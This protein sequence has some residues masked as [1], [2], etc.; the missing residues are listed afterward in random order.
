MLEAIAVGRNALL[1]LGVE[2]PT[3]PDEALIGKALQTLASQLQGRKIEELVD[4]PV[5]T[6][7]QTQAAMQLLGMLFAPIF[8]GMPGL[9]PLLSSTMVS[10]S[11]SFG[12]APA[13]TV[14]YA[15]HGMVL[16]AFLGEVETGYGFGQLAL[17]CSIRFN[18]REF[19]SIILLLFGGF[20][21]HRQECSEGNDTNAERWLYGW[22]GNWRFSKRWLQHNCLLLYQLF[23]W[24]RTGHLGTEIASYSAALAQV[25]QYSAQT[26]LDMMQ[27]T[28]QNLREIV[29]QPDCLIGTAYDETVMI[30]KHHQDNELQ[31][32][33]HCLHLQTV[34]CL[35][36][37]Q[38]HWLP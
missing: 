8:Q 22:H 2:L 21:Q 24:G 23:Q 33:R 35:L 30:P 29:N 4:L 5:M 32:D 14:G 18:A 28:V 26:F 25:K 7:P 9:L 13:S 19:K 36:L 16:C 34:A 11:L 38:L 1:Q 17:T 10:L 37:W 20:I 31:C 3:E 12:N 27:Q 6:N 15:I